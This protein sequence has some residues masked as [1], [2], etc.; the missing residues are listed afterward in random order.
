M[1]TWDITNAGFPG[2]RFAFNGAYTRAEQLG[3]HSTT[4]RSRGRS[5]CSVC[6]PC[7]AATWRRRARPRASSRS[8]SPGEFRQLYHGLF[9]QDDWRARPE[10][11]AQRRHPLRDQSRHDRSAEP[12]PR[13]LR[14]DGGE[15]DSSGGAGRV[16]AESDS[17][18]SGVA[19]SRCRAACCSQNGPTYNTLTKLLP[20]GGGCRTCSTTHR[21]FAAASGL[22]SY[23]L[24]FDN[25][26]QQGFSVGT[27]V[28]TTNDNGLT[29]TG[30]NLTNP[31]PSGQLVQ[32]VGF[33]ARACAAQ[34]GQN[35]TGNSPAGGGQQTEQ[36]P[37]AAGSQGAVL[38]ALGGERAARL[39][40]RL[41]G[42]RRPTS[43]RA[44]RTCRCSATST[45]FRSS[46]SRRRA[47]ATRRTRRS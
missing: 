26:N 34:L 14:H 20:R 3:G 27:P 2:G 35:L 17:R 18:D 6:R 7:R 21:A 38:H 23:D 44:A 15:S 29:F 45:T 8:R 46:T 5:S 12:Q 22:F 30:A 16:R 11:D 40:R 43:A 36:Q 47:S 1:Q 41:G 39:R 13:R 28:L 19:A 10:A 37:R 25:I 33:G 4:A 31:I 42:R 24:F 32:P 9:V